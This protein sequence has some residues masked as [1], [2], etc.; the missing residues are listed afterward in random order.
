MDNPV[1]VWIDGSCINNGKY[2]AVAGIG[3]FWGINHK[4][5]VSLKLH[6]KATNNRA[7]INAA[8]IAI[9]IAK[10]RNIHNLIIYTDSMF[11]INCATKWINGWK[12]NNWKTSSKKDVINK[13]DLL[14]LD[15]VSQDIKIKYIHVKA[16][17]GVFE[18]EEADKLAKKGALLFYPLIL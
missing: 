2:N 1:K 7:E 9:K 15:N 11:L 10:I 14:I 6:G 17:S 8:I 13:D 5:N 4:D 12:K 16:H 3:V 18:N